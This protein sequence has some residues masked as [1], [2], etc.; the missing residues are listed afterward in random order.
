M[1]KTLLATSVALAMGASTAQAAFFQAG[2]TGT[3]SFTA[4][5]FTFGACS[6]GGV[7]NVT[8]NAL[9]AN[10]VGSGIAGDGL[11]GVLNFSTTDGNNLNITSFSQDTYTATAGGNFALAAPGGTGSMT[12]FV[13]DSGDVS[14]DLT[15]RVGN[16]AFFGYLGTPAWNIDN[17]ATISGQGDPVTGVQEPLTTGSDSA[18]T[19]GV[20]GTPTL[21]QTGSALV[22]GGGTWTGTLVSSGNIGSAWGAFDSTPYTEV[23]NMTVNGVEAVVP[24]PA[25]VWLFGSGLLGLVGVARR[26]KQA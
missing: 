17:S 13:S 6:I 4:G 20:A 26:K 3:I 23:F 21:T 18:W 7:G 1:N 14:L 22:G 12:G 25:A 19:P 9:T 24:V 16:A 11:V 15:G 5:C 2:S 8:D 10:G